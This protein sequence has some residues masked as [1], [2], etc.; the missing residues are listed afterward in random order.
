[1]IVA[2]GAVVLGDRC[3]VSFVRRVS[4]VR[5]AMRQGLRLTALL[6]LSGSMLIGC[7]GVPGCSDER[8][9]TGTLVERTPEEKAAEKASMEGMRKAMEKAQGKGQEKAK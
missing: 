8:T 3:D 4:S 6:A 5:C 2:R 7:L 1:M 9:K